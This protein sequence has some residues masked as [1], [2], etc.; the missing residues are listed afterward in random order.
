MSS[1]SAV[2]SASTA[3]IAATTQPAPP[4]QRKDAD[5]DHDGDTGANKAAESGESSGRLNTV[6]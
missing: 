1:I 2:G 6:A 3:A 4:V 5:G